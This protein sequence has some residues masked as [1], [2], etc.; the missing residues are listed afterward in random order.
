MATKINWDKAD[1]DITYQ[2]NKIILP[3]DPGPMSLTDAITTLQRKQK[4]LETVMNVVEFIDTHPMDG[5]VAFVEAMKQKYGW[6]SPVPTPG[7]FGDKPPQMRSVRIGPAPEDVVQVPW[8]RFVL[9]GVEGNVN[10]NSMVHDGRPQFVIY[11]ELMKK[12]HAI[13]KELAAMTRAIL[14]TR[15]IYKGKAIR[16]RVKEDG[17]INHEVDPEFIST[18]RTRPEDL[19]LNHGEAEQVE[20]ALWTPIFR[21]AD[22]LKHRIP[23]KRGVLLE[24]PYGCGKTLVSTIT[25][26]HCVDNGWTFISLDDVRALADALLFAKRYAP[27]VI[28]SEDIDRV[29]SKRDQ[30]G[31]DLLNTIDGILSKDAQVITVLTTNFVEVLDKAMLRPGRLDAVISV[32]APDAESVKKLIHV[33]ARDLLAANADLTQVGHELAGNIP[34][35]IREV[36]ERSKLAMIQR[37]GNSISPDDLLVAGRGMKRHLELLQPKGG[38]PSPA[39]KLATSLRETIAGPMGN[40]GF[41]RLSKKVDDIHEEIVG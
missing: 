31:N 32:G 41:D 34:A 3:G 2:G 35:T 28:F 13:I 36:V 29:G 23:L 22:C 16:L 19:V 20:T 21:T 26:K 37:G 24:G 9:P 5:A 6:A 18:R 25:A 11:G 40:G 33:Y 7:F 8:G 4:D 38:E 10:T 17:T 12:D 39:E 15:S 1:P 27:A 30:R 14:K